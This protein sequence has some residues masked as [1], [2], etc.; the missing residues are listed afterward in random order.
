MRTI[1]DDLFLRLRASIHK[2][3]DLREGLRKVYLTLNR[4]SGGALGILRHALTNFGLA[5][6]GEASAGLAYYALFSIFPILVAAVSIASLFLQGELARASLT[7]WISRLLPVSATTVSAQID[8]IFQQRG[9]VTSLALISLLWSGSNVFAKVALNL[10][11]A[12]PQAKRTVAWQSRAMGLLIILLLLLLFIASLVLDPLADLATSLNAKLAQTFTGSSLLW[13]A[14]SGLLPYLLKILLFF[15]AYTLLPRG[16]AL[17]FK[18]RAWAALFSAS[19]WEGVTRLLLW[20]LARGLAN[21][22]ILY[23]SL[24]SIMLLLF[25]LYWSATIL[26]LGAHLCHAINVHIN[27]KEAFVPICSPESEEES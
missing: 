27:T 9:A 5:R 7:E 14:L 18:A 24:A 21:Y 3:E 17:H 11:R 20:A 10:N 1:W 6:G 8:I 16:G 25:W 12:F 13:A 19:L 15:L 26:F 22:E 4:L 23:G 2:R